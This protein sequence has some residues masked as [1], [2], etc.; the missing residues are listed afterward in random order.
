MQLCKNGLFESNKQSG[1]G[2][3]VVS[4]L[5]TKIFRSH[6]PQGTSPGTRRRPAAAS[7]PAVALPAIDI[8]I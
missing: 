2:I 5:L 6:C 3:T 7:A 8:I 1:K 4:H